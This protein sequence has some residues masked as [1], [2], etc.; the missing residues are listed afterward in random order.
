MHMNIMKSRWIPFFCFIFFDIKFMSTILKNYV[1]E[2]ANIL[3]QI[4][5][6]IVVLG[7]FLIC[8]W[9]LYTSKKN[10]VIPYQL[11][12]NQL[13]TVFLLLIALLFSILANS[14]IQNMA[15]LVI[16]SVIFI[17]SNIIVFIMVKNAELIESKK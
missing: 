17:N 9:L 10:I 5:D 16:T 3:I 8:I 6:V 13:L 7:F 1:S 11:S 12:R 15:L 2:S 14:F 4:M